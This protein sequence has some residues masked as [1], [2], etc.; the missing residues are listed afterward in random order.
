MSIRTA[1]V[2][3][4]CCNCDKLRNCKMGL[5]LSLFDGNDD[6]AVELT[7]EQDVAAA[8]A[9]VDLVSIGITDTELASKW[10]I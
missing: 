10:F 9:A 3:K 1:A 8:G 6:V 7:D 5:W 2:S 4:C